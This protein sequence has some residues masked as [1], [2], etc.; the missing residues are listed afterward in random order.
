VTTFA[1]GWRERVVGM[2]KGISCV[3]Q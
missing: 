1:S 3:T 2:E